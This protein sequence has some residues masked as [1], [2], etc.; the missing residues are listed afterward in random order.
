MP[1]V[2]EGSAVPVHSIAFRASFP[3]QAAGRCGACVQLKVLEAVTRPR[4]PG[5][6]PSPI[7]PGPRGG[8]AAPQTPAAPSRARKS[9]CGQGPVSSML[10]RA[11]PVRP[12]AEI[13]AATAANPPSK[14]YWAADATRSRACACWLV[15]CRAL[16]DG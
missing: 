2:V 5:G 6:E 7:R 15:T 9:R 11:N 1:I 8:R 3:K 12:C 16:G 10:E 4:R 13:P 14:T